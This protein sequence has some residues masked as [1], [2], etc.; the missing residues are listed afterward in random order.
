MKSFA[1]LHRYSFLRLLLP[2]SAGIYIGDEL[3]FR[4][5]VAPMGYSLLLLSLLL[6][7]LVGAYF[8]KRYTLRW[9]FGVLLFLFCLMGGVCAVN[10]QLQQTAIAFPETDAIYRVLITEHPEP[11]ERSVLCR[12]TLTERRDSLATTPLSHAVLLYLAKD[13]LSEQLLV[14]DE[15]L[16]AARFAPPSSSGNPDE[17]DY[18]RYLIRKQVS[19]TGFCAAHH[20]TLLSHQEAPSLRMQALAWRERLLAL[21]RNLGFHGDE[22]AVLSALTVGYKEELSEEIRETYSISGASHVLALSGLHIGI[23]YGLL[24][25]C[26][27][28]LP[29]Q[30][31]G[32]RLLRASVIIVLL[33]AFAFFTGL[34]PSVVRSVIMCSLFILSQE[35]GRSSF[36]MNTLLIAAFFML[37]FQPGW[38]FDVG[39]QLSFCA[40]VAILLIQPKL[41]RIIPVTHRVGR[42]VWG[43][44]SVSLAAQVGTAP[45]VLLYFSRF[46]THFL[47]TNLVVIPLVFIIMYAAVGLLLLTPFLVLQSAVAFLVKG[48]IEGLNSSV[49]WVEQ[50]PWASLDN[51]WIY[52]LEVFAFYLLLLL[53]IRYCYV[54][55]AQSLMGSLLCLLFLCVFHTVMRW[56]DSPRQSLE[57]Y[58]IRGCPA[59]HCIAADG[60]SWIVYA[61][62]F[63]DEKRLHR[64]VSSHWQRLRLDS[65]QPVVTAEYTADSFVWRNRILSFSGYRVCC[66]SD[67]RWRYQ[68]A[69]SPLSVDYLYL[70][71]GYDGRVEWLSSLFSFRTVILDSSLSNYRLEAFKSECRRL[72][73][74]YISL[75][76]KGSVRFL[77]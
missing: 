52:P 10:L 62:S 33:W 66:I 6:A 72:G 30:W 11:K 7:L 69:S 56:N 25:F 14:G 77:L 26:L 74:H 13:S 55:S 29:S 47:L 41:Y 42:Y 44:M 21:Y 48:L 35:F 4:K 15:L 70:C 32:V 57:F 28:C 45:L 43:L 60:R 5:W 54:R 37:L 22:F 27:K 16:V 65:P 18:A 63:P 20:W 39:F 31:R 59:V 68:T 75:S 58:N 3:F 34:S 64:A 9:V 71:R 67:N 53:L 23:L 49:R 46:S 24:F 19:G 76:E 38:L 2:L 17:F 8:L 1:F 73:I 51:V 40:V 12:A 50:L 61:D 36:S